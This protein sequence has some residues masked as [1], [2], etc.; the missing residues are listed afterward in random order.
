MNLDK[1]LNLV[2]YINTISLLT[3]LSINMNTAMLPELL[4]VTA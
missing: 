1:Y 4:S 2:T 3:T